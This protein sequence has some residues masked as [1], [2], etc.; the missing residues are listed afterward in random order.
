MHFSWSEKICLG[1]LI[2]AWVTW[3]SHMIGNTLVHAEALE[4]SRLR[5]RYKRH[6]SGR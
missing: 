2:A 5:C 1:L 4:K 6:G 3:G